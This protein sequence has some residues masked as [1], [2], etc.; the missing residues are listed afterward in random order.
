VLINSSFSMVNGY[1]D[2][3]NIFKEPSAPGLEPEFGASAAGSTRD[4]A[5]G[6]SAHKEALFRSF[7]NV[8]EILSRS[9]PDT[10]FVLRPHPSEKQEPWE[11]VAEPLSNVQVIHEGSVVPWLLACEALIHNGCTTAVEATVARKPAIAFCPTKSFQYDD[12]VPNEISL[13]ASNPSQLCEVLGNVLKGVEHDQIA[14]NYSLLAKSYLTG[15]SGPLASDR[16][17]DVLS[18]SLE[19]VGRPR[20]PQL[21]SYLRGRLHCTVRMVSKRYIKA[22]KPEHTHN[23]A[24]QNH[25][26]PGVSMDE[27]RSRIARLGDTLGR[28]EDVKVESV[29]EHIYRVFT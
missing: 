14:T 11:R 17:V 28:F 15:L 24:Y 13:D 25:H 2:S 6:L 12:R 18:Q 4:F 22:R 16:I 26:F 19:G 27:L 20:T 5:M 3:F 9:F 7:M 1:F 10:T 21:S 23:A 8:L 29:A